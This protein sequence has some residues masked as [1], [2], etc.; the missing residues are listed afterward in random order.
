MST[1]AFTEIVD[2]ATPGVQYLG[3]ARNYLDPPTNAQPTDTN[4]A[5]WQ[6]IR[7]LSQ[8][9]ATFSQPLNDGTFTHI[10]DDRASYTWPA[11]TPVYNQTLSVD[12]DGV[13]DYTTADLASNF[14]IQRTTP[15]SILV[16]VRFN[17]AGTV[18]SIINEID[19][20]GNFPGWSLF[21]QA[22][23]TIRFLIEASAVNLIQFTTTATIADTNW[24]QIIVTY[25][26]DSTAATSLIYIDGVLAPKTNNNDSLTLP[27]TRTQPMQLGRFT[28]T[29]FAG[30]IDEPAIFDI[31]L[32]ATRVTQLYNGGDALDL[33]TLTYYANV[34]AW[35]R[36]GDNSADVFPTLTGM[37]TGLP[38]TMV[39]MT[40]GDIEADVP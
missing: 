30:N 38:M 34:R 33:R 35:W 5:V 1:K 4:H 8:G 21:R 40:A 25:T 17:A 2:S 3:K 9:G 37:I 18:Q 31:A 39:N 7:V 29:Y 24:H 27:I 12:F 22:N 14:S 28:T 15:F 32:S 11:I 16:W 26:G 6:I 20:A 36:M 10:W 13:N 19:I 23:N